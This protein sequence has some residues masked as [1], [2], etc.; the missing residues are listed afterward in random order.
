LEKLSIKAPAKI[1]LYL[2][3]LRKRDDG[4]HEIESLMQAIDLYDEIALE[5][6]DKIE[7]T[8]NDATL[9]NDSRN[10]AFR[11]ASAMQERF[12]FPGVTINLK[13]NIPMGAGLGGGSSDAAF[14]LRAL[15]RLYDLHPTF[16]ELVRIAASLGSDVP[17]FLTGGQALVKGRGEILESVSL[18]TDYEI[19]VV[20]PPLAL[21][22]AEV[23]SRVKFSLTKKRVGPL[24]RNG[25]DF[26]GF[27]RLANDFR[28]DLE[29]VAVE[30]Y[31]ILMELIRSLLGAGAFYSSMTGSG[32]SFFG[33]FKSGT[34]QMSELDY[35]K[36]RGIK[37]F[38]CR[39]I[40]LPPYDG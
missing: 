20:S 35:L 16:E 29:E 24:L 9:P 25:I 4:F 12:P 14:V 34:E 3:V 27:L 8:S 40:L 23:Y 30:K 38:R 17:F 11:A 19:V 18:P 37:V 26:S 22:T 33:L 7:L 10:L 2:E 5:K 15:C 6:S 32:S 31:P 28:N 1:N 39:P 21:S 13:K 36:E